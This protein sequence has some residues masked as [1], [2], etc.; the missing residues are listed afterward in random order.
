MKTAKKIL[1]ADD[2]PS[3][4]KIL[5][6]R[7]R[8]NGYKIIA[9]NDG[10]RTI[11]LVQREK[12]DLIVLDIRMPEKNGYTVFQDLRESICARSIPIVF[13]TAL[14]PEEAK[15]KATQLGADGFVPKSAGTEE[16]VVR[17]RDIFDRIEHLSGTS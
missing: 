5:G 17:I 9:A 8:E 10:A 13:F 7:L 1:I 14:S 6:K 12:P 16:V 4:V 11:E 3:V 15:E 2:E